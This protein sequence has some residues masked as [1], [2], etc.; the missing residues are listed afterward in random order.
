[1]REKIQ[2]VFNNLASIVGRFAG[3]QSSSLNYDLNVDDDDEEEE[4][5]C[6]NDKDN[7]PYY[8]QKYFIAKQIVHKLTREI[9]IYPN[10][11]MYV[12]GD[13]IQKLMSPLFLPDASQ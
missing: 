3:L 7:V 12:D 11:P 13:F 9:P 5:E 6:D 4:E 2:T 10:V 8:A 1:M